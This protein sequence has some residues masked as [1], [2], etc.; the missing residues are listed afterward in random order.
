MRRD[1]YFRL[2]VSGNTA[3]WF[4]D[5]DFLSGAVKYIAL[6]K[7]RKLSIDRDGV[8]KSITWRARIATDAREEGGEMTARWRRRFYSVHASLSD[9]GRKTNASGPSRVIC[10]ARLLDRIRITNCHP[11]AG[12][13][14]QRCAN[15]ENVGPLSLSF[16]N[17]CCESTY[18]GVGTLTGQLRTQF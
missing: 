13:Y 4:G 1:C 2:W 14:R 3:V 7:L 9:H 10:V 17:C 8:I 16:S 15:S 5:P 6:L 12:C 18:G 11:R